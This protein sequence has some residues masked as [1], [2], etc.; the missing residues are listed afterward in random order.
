MHAQN[1]RDIPQAKLD[2]EINVRFL[3]NE[4]GDLFFLL[5][6]NNVHIILFNL[7]KNYNMLSK[8]KKDILGKRVHETVTL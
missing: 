6:T 7:R 3:L 8:G 2:R 4:H 5:H 1:V